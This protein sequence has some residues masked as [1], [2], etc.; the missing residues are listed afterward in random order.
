MTTL[1]EPIKKKNTG[2]FSLSKTA[3]YILL[4]VG[5]LVMIIPFVWMLS[6]SLKDQQQLFAWPP[7]WLPNPFVWKNYTDVWTR[8]NFSLYGWNT[9]KITVAVTIGR[10]ILCSMAGYGFA[11]M[12]FPGKDFLFMLTLA[13][14]M[15]SSQITIVPNFIIMRYLG[16][17]DTH[18]GVILP[19]L[20]DGFSIFLMRQ[21][22]LTFPYELEDA[23]KL[24]GCNP[25]MFY[26]RI[27]IPNSKPILAT[28]AVMTFQGV[29]N[30][31][32]WPLVMLTSPAKRTLAVGLSYLVGQ[33]TTRWDLQM[34]GSVLTV[35]PIL[36]LYFVLQKYFV[37]SI[38]MTGLKG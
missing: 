30:D 7:S 35:L 29:W 16:L 36:L 27:L 37:Q 32:L 28:L 13:T 22:F 38:K 20:A 3:A 10:L 9:I 2:R 1:P 24:D 12:K 21:F 18:F 17:V 31:F 34:A 33:Y 15:I 11:R 23:A 26:L 8:I 25:L 14:M 5:A 6:T 4:A 19:Q